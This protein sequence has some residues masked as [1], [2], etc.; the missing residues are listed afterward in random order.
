M[1]LTMP[2]LAESVTEGTVLQ[3]FKQPGDSF[4]TDDALCEIETEKVNIEFPAPF[5]GTLDEIVA[6]VGDTIPVGGVLCRVSQTATAAEAAA[7]GPAQPQTVAPAAEPAGAGAAPPHTPARNGRRYSPAVLRLAS[8]HNVNL[9]RLTGTGLGGRITRKDVTAYLEDAE[10]EAAPVGAHGRAPVPAPATTSPLPPVSAGT[11]EPL[12]ATRKAIAEHMVRSRQTSP[13]AWMMVE[14]DASNL[15]SRRDAEKERFREEKGYSL[16]YLPFFVEIVAAT[17]RDHPRLNS[18][19]ADDAVLLHKDINIGIA[20]GAESGLIVPVIHNADRYNALGL[21]EIIHDLAERARTR[22]LKLED[23]QGGTFTVNNTGAFGSIA[24]APIINQPQAAILTLEAIVK[25]PVVVGD[26]IAIRPMVNLCISFD[27]RILDGTD[28]G[29][30]MAA[31][32][33][34]VEA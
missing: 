25:R 14:A 5:E 32:K 4:R 30:F 18:S 27:H 20:V 13:H 31:L 7:S 21:G 6:Q 10:P 11:R 3:W 24:S 26:A 28:I 1:D 22:K 33:Q 15:A 9:S 8:E 12:T 2:M 23:I 34:R 29:S 16:T 19:W 17:L